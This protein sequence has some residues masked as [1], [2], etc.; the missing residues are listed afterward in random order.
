MWVG[1]PWLGGRTRK[2]SWR[3]AEGAENLQGRVTFTAV[4][5]LM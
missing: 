2:G 1:V 4:S 3:P 5:I